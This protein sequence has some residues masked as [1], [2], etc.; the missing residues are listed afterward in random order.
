MPFHW[1]RVCLFFICIDFSIL[2]IIIHKQKKTIIKLWR[3]YDFNY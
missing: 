1:A 2:N 3:F